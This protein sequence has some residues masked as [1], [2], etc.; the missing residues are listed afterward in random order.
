MGLLTK[1]GGQKPLFLFIDVN[2]MI[3]CI[4]IVKTK[5]KNTKIFASMK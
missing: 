2:L 4:N 3:V 5:K 1:G